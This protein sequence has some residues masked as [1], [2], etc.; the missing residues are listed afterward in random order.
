MIKVNEE[1]VKKGYAPIE[2]I[3]VIPSGGAGPIAFEEK[4]TAPHN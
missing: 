3:H 2:R 4:K 1:R